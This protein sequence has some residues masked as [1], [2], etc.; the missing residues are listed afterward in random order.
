MT[1][2]GET[3]QPE[4]RSKTTQGVLRLQDVVDLSKL[5]AIQDSF[6][7]AM[8]MAAVTVDPD[9]V[10]LTRESNFQNICR[11]IRSRPDGQKR[12]HACDAQGGREADRL[13]RP[14]IY[15][16]SSGLVDAAAPISIDGQFLGSILC[17]QVT[18]QGRREAQVEDIVER[19][20]PLGLSREEVVGAVATTPEIPRDRFDSALEMLA[21]AANHM[22]E[23]GM[24]NLVQRRLLERSAEKAAT[25]KALR[26]AQLQ[27]LQARMNPHFLFNSLTVIGYTALDEGARRTEEICYT[28]TDLL[29]YSLRNTDSMVPLRDELV[30]I[31][32]C[33]SL[34]RLRFGDQLTT[35]V[36]VEPAV[37]DL[38][39]PCMFLQPLVENA[40]IHGVESLT[41]PATVTVTARSRGGR[42]VIE[43][44]DD[45]VGMKPD[46]VRSIN[47]ERRPLVD[48]ARSRPALGL[49]TVLTRLESE[50]GT[51]LSINVV[52]GPNKG[53]TITLSWPI[54]FVPDARR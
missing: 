40:I 29:R 18:L 19:C 27:A 31:E 51:N 14:V 17:G 21:L 6:V 20:R 12:C 46:Q 49:H 48:A 38:P 7:K 2:S 8:G 50:Y 23:I 11:L 1:S 42:L 4:V 53:T 16:C 52:S 45:G 26:D 47:A 44:G 30:M 34:H 37:A 25:E 41:R 54:Q 33:L 5:Q 43:V 28:L 24:T 3:R 32:N 13:G 35:R 10:P 22:A 39:V 36:E 15:T 9:G